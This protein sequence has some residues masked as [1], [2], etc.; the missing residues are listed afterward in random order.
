MLSSNAVMPD[1]IKIAMSSEYYIHCLFD[2][3]PSHII[4]LIQMDNIAD[5]KLSLAQ[6][7]EFIFGMVEKIVIGKCRK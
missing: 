6:M 1:K 7:M 2:S 5:N 3:L 4:R